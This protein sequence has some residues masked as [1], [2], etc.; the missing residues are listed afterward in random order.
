MK[1]AMRRMGDVTVISIEGILDIE[2]TQPFRRVC[3][4]KLLSRKVIFNM[5]SANFVGSTGLQ[6]FLETIRALDH[7]CEHGLKM[8]GVKAEFRRLFASLESPKLSY[9]EEVNHAVASF[10][11]PPPVP[12]TILEATGSEAAVVT[13]E[14]DLNPTL[15]DVAPGAVGSTL[16]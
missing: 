6:S 1:A 4:E 5:S 7:H 8:V 2:H 16:R 13:S 15:P 10:A 3:L 11:L 12:Q 14:S 9:F